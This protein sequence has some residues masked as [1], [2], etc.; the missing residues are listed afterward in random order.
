MNK[1]R[2]IKV[3]TG[4]HW[5][6]APDADLR[7]L[8]GCPPDS[9]KHL[10][11]RGLIVPTEEKGVSFET[12]PNAILLSDIMLQNGDFANM[13]EFP[14]LQMLY[15]QGM[16][17]PGHPGNTGVKPLLMGLREQVNAQMRY[18]YRG[19]YG[20]T[21]EKELIEAGVAADEA[22]EMMAM[23]LKFAF[24]RIRDTQDFIDPL[25][26]DA[27]RVEVRNGVAIRRLRLNVFE[28]DYHGETI[29]VDLNL[30][31][32]VAYEVPY[33]LG[34]R[35]F[36]REY[37]AVIHA[38]EGDGWDINRPSMS[39]ILMYHGRIYLIDAGPNITNTLIALGIGINEIEGI[40]HTHSHDDHFAGLTTLLRADRRIKYFATPL[41]RT[42][43]VR[44]LSALLS[45]EEDRFADFFELHDLAFDT[46]ND[47]DGLEVKPIFSPHPV[48]TSVFV[49]RTLVEDGYR[50]YAHFADIVAFD[51]LAGMV[52]ADDSEAGISQAFHDRVI[53]DYLTPADIKK[54]DIGGGLIHGK[55][56]DFRDD[57]SAKIV[58][59]H[60]A[61]KLTD[62][63]KEIGS[64]APFG[65][66]DRLIPS[67]QEFEFRLAFG[68]LRA[69]F[70]DA[71]VHQIHILL[72]NETI[73]FNPE[74]II[75]K[76]GTT[77]DVLFLVLT[78]IVE[79]IRS[80]LGIHNSL[81]A[82]TLVGEMSGLTRTPA[83]HTYRAA[84]FVKVLRIP[85][86][87]FAKIVAMND[88]A[89]EIERLGEF[90]DLLSKSWLFGEVISHTTQNRIAKAAS[91]DAYP[92]GHVF[93]MTGNTT[94]NLIK[95]GRLERFID[96]EVF[97]IL[98][99]GDFFGEETAVFKT[100]G[101]FS[102]RAIEPVEICRIPGEV[103]GDIPIARWKL[104]ETYD[105]RIRLVLNTGLG[106]HLCFLWRKEYSV[107]VKAMD[108]HH[109]K[110]F[111][112]GANL[113]AAIEARKGPA[114]TEEALNF[115]IDYT[116]YHFAEEVA[117]LKKHGYPDLDAHRQRHRRLIEQIVDL[118][119]NL[120]LSGYQT[121]IDLANFFQE[122][123]VNHILTED[124]K[125]GTFL[126]Q[127]GCF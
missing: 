83:S 34:F 120:E 66:V 61:Q 5:V 73:D 7:V 56:E 65:T 45:M 51:V 85:T 2:K 112:M 81:Y 89:G 92:E 86:K 82:G 63:E 70:P 68:F 57:P 31:P 30:P 102:I 43:V 121:T 10:M 27:G 38:G 35:N 99:V 100:P 28:F 19:N 78:G 69:Y 95:S 104:L 72:N 123:I 11:K 71:P 125:Y 74:T 36:K 109:R 113:Q 97:E 88:L 21:S 29:A 108:D 124:R 119:K 44:K 60:T 14:V 90:R 87:L 23:K 64:G 77:C 52:R 16:I 111:E 114:A 55:A 79:A 91:V 39:S 32:R 76:E 110:L 15:R 126:N 8:C 122:W 17:L 118:E 101:V 25:Y 59:A 117:L 53:R 6:E 58:L 1:L 46:W 127:R 3:S 12:G 107:N 47:I 105:K 22:A 26:I 40:F 116:R 96:D 9:V 20:L 48:E 106:R 93:D 115:L 50:S 67:F 37:F 103:L 75:L 98:D 49:F 84:S 13:G 94:V 80:D 62:R 41:V 24:G 4:I 18:I 33:L 54:L 42:S